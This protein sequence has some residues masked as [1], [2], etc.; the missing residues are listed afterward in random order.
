MFEDLSAIQIWLLIGGA[1]VVAF[2]AGR[3]S[4][5]GHPEARERFRSLIRE[6]APHD[7]ELL[8][9]V[10]Q[11]EVDRLAAEGKTVAAAKVVRRALHTGLYHAT[12]IV[13][14]R[15]RISAEH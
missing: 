2:C 15:T 5:G 9:S 7:F 1:T 6:S 8:T 11:A 12:Q 3:A 10:E 4:M 13:D 14:H